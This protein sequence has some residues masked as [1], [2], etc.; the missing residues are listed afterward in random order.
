MIV[1]W[2][3]LLITALF[4]YLFG[5]MDTMVLAS[6]FV[7]RR[8]LMRLG[9]HSRWL[10][11][12]RRLFGISGFFKLLAV[13]LVKNLIPLLIGIKSSLML[14]NLLPIIG[15]FLVLITGNPF[16]LIFAFLLTGLRR[17]SISNY[18]NQPVITLSGGNSS[19]LNA[20]HG[21]FAIG[22]VTAPL[23][24]LACTRFGAIG[25]RI[26]VYVILALLLL[27]VFTSAFMKMDSVTYSRE[28]NERLSEIQKELTDFIKD[29]R[30]QFCTGVLDPRDDAQWQAYLD[31]LKALRYDEWVE[32]AQTAYDR[33]QK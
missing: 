29:R 4:A 17:F 21:F 23:I 33:M 12:F 14:L 2:I 16:I 18:D 10:S 26:A 32:I 30:A 19:P 5:S 27:S 3:L 13:E 25:W 8:N 31:N 24:A 1:Y 11:N 15:F 22:A 28:E 6:N 20:L 9:D 7:F